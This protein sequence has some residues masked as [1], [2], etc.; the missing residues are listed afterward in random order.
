MNTLPKPTS[1]PGIPRYSAVKLLIALG[2]LFVVTP[3]IEELQRGDLIEAVLG[4]LVMVFCVRAVSRKPRTLILAIILGAPA[5]AGKWINRLRPDLLPPA[6]ALVP[7]FIFFIFVVAHLVSF[8]VRSPRVDTDVI[9]AG[10]AGFVMLGLVWAPLYL[11]AAQLNPGA[12]ALMS[13]GKFDG[14]SAFYLSFITLCTVGY[15]DVTPVSKLAR[16]LAVIEAITGLFYMAVLI[17]R[18]VSIYSSAPASDKP[19][20][21]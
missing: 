20:D 7:T 16:M 2:C 15:G 17:S 8:I 6:W 13:G 1:G 21:R 9:C 12:F 3:F 10:V 18:L 4:T 19:A 11:L 14:F 5:V